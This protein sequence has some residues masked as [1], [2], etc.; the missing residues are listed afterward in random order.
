[1][2]IVLKLIA[3]AA[4]PDRAVGAAPALH[5]ITPLP[6]V[7]RRADD[8]LLI[9]VRIKPGH[10]PKI[11]Q[12]P[13]TEVL[14]SSLGRVGKAFL[15]PKQ[16]GKAH[17][18]QPEPCFLLNSHGDALD[19]SMTALD[20]WLGAAQFRIGRVRHKVLCE[21]AEVV[22]LLL[23][24]IPLVGVPLTPYVETRDC[25]AQQCHWRWE[26]RPSGC[27]SAHEWQQVGCEREYQPSDADIGARL[28]VTAAPPLTGG[29]DVPHDDDAS[30]SFLAR[31][32]EAAEP[33]MPAPPRRLLARRV[34]AMRRRRGECFRVLSYNLLADCYSRHWDEPGSV[35]DYCSPS[36]TRPECRMARLLEEVLAFAPD[37]VMLQEVDGSWYEQHW[38][39]A[40]HARGYAGYFS[41][42]QHKSS[43]EGV[44]TFVRSSAFHLVE[45]RPLS[46]SID[47]YN[48]GA[49]PAALAPLLATHSSTAEGVSSLPTVAH[50]LLIREAK[51]A[52]MARHQQ[53]PRHLILANTHLYFSNPGMHVRV[54]QSA[55]LLHHAHQWVA[56]LPAAAAPALIL[57]GDLN[58]DS[59]DAAVRLLTCGVVEADSPDWLHGMLNWS[60]SLDLPAAAHDAASSAAATLSVCVD[61]ETFYIEAVWAQQLRHAQ[62]LEEAAMADVE[63]AASLE[64]A[65]SIARELHLL[66]RAIERLLM[67]R[68]S[69][70]RAPPKRAP[71]RKRAQAERATATAADPTA[72]A[73]GDATDG[74]ATGLRQLAAAIVSDVAAGR[75]LLNSRALAAAEV[76]RQLRLPLGAMASGVTASGSSRGGPDSSSWYTAA[77]TRLCTLTQRLVAAKVALRARVA[78]ESVPSEGVD[79]EATRDSAAGCYDAAKEAT[80]RWAT[81][82]AGV[83][84]TQPTPLQSVYGLHSQPTH[85]VPGY[86]NTLDWICV[87]SAR[88][89]VVGVAP[90]PPLEELTRHVAMPSVEWPSDHVSL[91]ADL[92]WRIDPRAAEPAVGR[93][94]TEEAAAT[95]DYQETSEDATARDSTAP[96]SRRSGPWAADCRSPAGSWIWRT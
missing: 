34:N 75:S 33:V 58:S 36:L 52:T 14:A 61:A 83:R 53:P 13:A 73:G 88:L 77:H 64:G 10:S 54:M 96:P 60:P 21:P 62:A 19:P 11:L 41:K 8:A 68:A 89:D 57:A 9:E 48:D 69:P 82:A 59:T 72:D 1:M 50:L 78:S 2:G 37:V 66:R 45:A 16:R 5:P 47:A 49:Q 84:L 4:S 30:L 46:L 80:W 7:V 12:R 17:D 3:L 6:I 27:S 28:R 76:A 42:K 32:A 31:V 35:H 22:S 70:K 24:S 81:R 95:S 74:D 56:Q 79:P 86:A 93:A 39:P 71:P 87:D 38:S 26:R 92:A 43:Q 85:A 67:A 94:S 18:K 90:L 29:D 20:A 25:D 55:K 51:P 15:P 65:R 23:P 40:M 63:E 44:A 91:C